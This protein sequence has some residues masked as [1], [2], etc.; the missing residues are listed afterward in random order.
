MTNDDKEVTIQKLLIAQQRLQ[1]LVLIFNL[2]EDEEKSSQVQGKLDELSEQ[3]DILIVEAMQ[4]W[5]ADAKTVIEDISTA[6][7]NMRKAITN[8]RNDKKEADSFI[9]VIGFI[10]DILLIARSFLV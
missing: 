6:N 3:I 1:S 9:K 5:L 8:I 7:S 10:D 2:R 4:D